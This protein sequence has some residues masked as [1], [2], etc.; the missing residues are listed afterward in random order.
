MFHYY[1]SLTNFEVDEVSPFSLA[2]GEKVADRTDEGFAETCMFDKKPPH[3][4]LSPNSFAT[5][6]KLLATSQVRK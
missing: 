6:C 2:S 5:I 4:G 3:P 1:P